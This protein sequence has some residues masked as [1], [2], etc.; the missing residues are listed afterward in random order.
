MWSQFKQVNKAEPEQF[1]RRYEYAEGVYQWQE[2]GRLV[3]NK[4]AIK[5]V[6][7]NI[8]MYMK[9]ND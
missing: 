1:E 5:S 6:N 7:A 9:E 8:I 2:K 3:I 4:K